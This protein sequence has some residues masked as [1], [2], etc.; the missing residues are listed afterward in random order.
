[1]TSIRQQEKNILLCCQISHKILCTDT[2]LH[3]I[4]NI[5]Q[6]SRGGPRLPY[7]VVKVLPGAIVIPGYNNKTYRIDEITWDEKPIKFE[8]KKEENR[9]YMKYYETLY[10]NS[11][12]DMKQLSIILMP[13]VREESSGI[14]GPIPL[15]PEV[16]NMTSLSNK[17]WAKLNLMKSMGESRHTKTLLELAEQLNGTKEIGEDITRWNHKFAKDLT[18]SRFRIIKPE[19]ILVNKCKATY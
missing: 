5:F 1:L 9:S 19:T 13:K 2:I 12:S 15:I 14:S 6:K 16:C 17:Q 8:C 10:N 11:I 3:Q 7:D 18:Q 4:S